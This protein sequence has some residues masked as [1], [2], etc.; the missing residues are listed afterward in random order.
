[1]TPHPSGLCRAAA[2]VF[3]VL[4]V[5]CQQYGYPPVKLG[6]PFAGLSSK[7]RASKQPTLPAKLTSK[8]KANVE[9]AMARSLEEQGETDRAIQ[10]YADVLRKDSRRADAHH[11][12]AV[13]YDKKGE[14]QKAEEHY[15]LA[16]KRNPQNAQAYCDY[17]YSCYL[18]HRWRE[19]EL[20]LRKS[21]ELAPGPKRAHNNLGLL[22]ART[23]RPKEALT[24]FQKAGSPPAEAHTNLA[25][26]LMFEERLEESRKQFELA[27][28][29][30]PASKVAATGLDTLHSMVAGPGQN[31]L[32]TANH[33]EQTVHGEFGAGN[34]GPLQR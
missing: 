11:R 5:G 8:Q 9:M 33:E 28:A 7:K 29:A 22:L 32:L 26:V 18:Q 17:G 1:M 14:C 24:E 19:A 21:I 23:E 13:L 2:A 10:V 4:L 27:L 20:N 30:D 25:F 12:L 3:I 16:L 34:R 31:P 6:N 15:Q